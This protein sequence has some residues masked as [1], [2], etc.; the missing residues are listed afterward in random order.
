[1]NPELQ[2][3]YHLPTGK[4]QYCYVPNPSTP[5]HVVLWETL[6]YALPYNNPRDITGNVYLPINVPVGEKL[7]IF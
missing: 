6:P 4:W 7:Y 1:M 3:V 5:F 2:L